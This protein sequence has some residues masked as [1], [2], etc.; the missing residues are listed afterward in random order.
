[1]LISS[2]TKKYYDEKDSVRILNPKQAC[3]FWGERGIQPLSIYPSKDKKTGEPVIIFVFSK[4]KTQEA[5]KD[6]LDMRPQYN[7]GKND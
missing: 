2:L 3:Y 6:W 5:Y 4:S 7:E 1:M